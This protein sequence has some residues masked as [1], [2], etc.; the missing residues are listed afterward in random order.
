MEGMPKTSPWKRRKTLLQWQFPV[1]GFPE[2][3]VTK[4]LT[5]R[6]DDKSTTP[7]VRRCST[8]SLTWYATR[9]R[10]SRQNDE[11]TNRNFLGQIPEV[12]IRDSGTTI[13][14]G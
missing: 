4:R 5:I 8:N 13:T 2:E 12:G 11:R 7:S 3:E 6:S 9:S 1:I 14:G 10:E